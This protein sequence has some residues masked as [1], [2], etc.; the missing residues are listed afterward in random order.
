M[1]IYKSIKKD[2]SFKNYFKTNN[3]FL[4]SGDT[5]KMLES[6]KKEQLVDLLVT[7]PPYNIGKSYEKN[8]SIDEYY[9]NHF[10]FLTEAAN[11]I[12]PNGSI[13]YQLG[14][15]INEDGYIVPLDYIFHKIFS[16]LGFKLK[17]RIIWTFGHGFHAKKRFSG[18]YET[19]NWYVKNENYTFNLDA[20]RVLQK[21]PSKR[22]YK[23]PNKGKISSN[24]L[25][26]NP[27]DVWIDIPHVKGNHIEKTDHPCQ[28][29]IALIIRLIRAL[30]NENE[31][32]FDPYMG[33]GSAGAAANLENRKF[34]G[35]D[36][37][38]SYVQTAK[39][40]IK[41]SIDGSLNYRRLSK[42]I[43]DHKKS[44][45]SKKPKEN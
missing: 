7:S 19:I 32:I 15:H 40:R 31:I 25:G 27:S 45:L 5:K 36:L 17:N 12:K 29:P 39:K 1:K 2:F 28:F 22:F 35:G 3:N 33:V 37:H 13:C 38:H 23:G 14:N 41:S 21:Y 20:I 18:R 10:D 42:P 6:A 44:P 34:I 11:F 43:Y 8:I 9:K 16:D 26:M 4:W 30:T 24:K